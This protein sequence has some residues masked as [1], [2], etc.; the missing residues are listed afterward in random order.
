MTSPTQDRRYGL[1]SGTA[2]KAPCKAASTGNLVLNGE[3]T[4][5]GI[6][7]V[8]GDRVLV[9][10][11]TSATANGIYLV[12]TGA[13]TRDVD[14]NDNF[15]FVSGTLVVVR[16]GTVNSD[17]SWMCTS[18]NPI[19]IGTS[20]I[21]FTAIV[22]P[23]SY[24]SDSALISFLAAGAGAVADSLQTHLRGLIIEATDY[25]GTWD[26]TAD[27]T[28]AVN[29]ALTYAATLTYGVVRLPPKSRFSNVTIP[30]GCSL[31]GDGVDATTV[32]VTDLVNPCV[33]MQNYTTLQGIRFNY[34]NQTSTIGPTAYPPTITHG[35]EDGSYT[36]L[37][38][39]RAW[40]AYEF[41]T[42]GDATHTPQKVTIENID[43][44]PF[45]KG[46]SI[47]N[48]FD[49]I[50]ASNIHFVQNIESY[51]ATLLAW[52]LA[53]GTALNFGQMD[54]GY[55]DNFTVYG[56]LKGISM[57]SG[58]VSGCTNMSTFSNFLVDLC[59]TPI[60][61]GAHDS[62]VSFVNGEVTGS[63]TGQ[64][65]YL[66]QQG[67]SDGRFLSFTNVNFRSFYI[68]ALEV[69]TNVLLNNCGFNNFNTQNS[70]GAYEAIGVKTNNNV[71]Q[72]NN[73]RIAMDAHANSRA[74]LV[75]GVT[76]NQVLISNSYFTNSVGGVYDVFVVDQN[77]LR[78][79]GTALAIGFSY[80]GVL[81]GVLNGSIM[82]TTAAPTTGTWATGDRF[83]N[84]APKIG[85]PKGWV[86]SSTGAWVSEG[87]L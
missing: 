73:C 13:W 20:S 51:G 35:T 60:Y 55:F 72:I 16:L 21:T 76:G 45:Y 59:A 62:G 42:L 43:G 4:V 82:A 68:S 63:A 54:A 80:K 66:G 74:V 1:S 64:A 46:I 57:V 30:H 58:V 50:H 17:T 31:I 33:K 44:Y 86:Y 52:V 12:D 75:S 38:D 85:D 19:T 87:N 15:D 8:T 18:S 34:P 56:Y 25:N 39:L 47:D 69:R 61:I 36:T 6:A 3:Q 22:P 32:N 24:G 9:K 37:R 2:I 83:A 41:I 70:G 7:C 28:A 53:N 81:G 48:S 40:R 65:C 11:Q 10:N 77:T 67:A 14:A 78:I 79:N 23:A 29:R 26:G 84:I 71:V 49:S 27:D 5:D